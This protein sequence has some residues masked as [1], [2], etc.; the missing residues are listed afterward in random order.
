M[1]NVFSCISLILCLMIAWASMPSFALPDKPDSFIT[2]TVLA[3]NSALVQ[4]DLIVNSIESVSD[5]TDTRSFAENTALLPV[6]ITDIVGVSL[7]TAGV[8]DIMCKSSFDCKGE[9]FKENMVL[10]TYRNCTDLT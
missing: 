9:K 3:A 8:S 5:K 2:Q 4:A 10:I 7:L 1:K 6:T